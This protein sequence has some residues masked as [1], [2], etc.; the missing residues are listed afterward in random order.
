MGWGLECGTE[1]RLSRLGWDQAEKGRISLR[2][3]LGGACSIWRIS[4]GKPMRSGGVWVGRK[5]CRR[6]SGHTGAPNVLPQS[7]PDAETRE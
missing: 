2:G 6:G 3:G 1:G 4:V 7:S 5:T